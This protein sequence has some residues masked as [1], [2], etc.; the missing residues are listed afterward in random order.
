MR[1]IVRVKVPCSTSNL[2][3]GLDCLGLALS[4]YFDLTVS[5]DSKHKTSFEWQG[6]P[7]AP[8]SVEAARALIMRSLETVFNAVGREM[9]PLQI[10]VR[11]EIPI[12]AGLGSSGAA[13]VGGL[14]AA[15]RLCD[16]ALGQEDIITLATEIEGHPDNVSPAVCGGLTISYMVGK[17]VVVHPC[18]IA[19]PL[20][21]AIVLPAVEK[22]ST[23]QT[24]KLFPR[25][26]DL[27]D[28]LHNQSRTAAIVA[29]LLQGD[30]K[31]GRVL[32]DD[33]LHQRQRSSLMP[34]LFDATQAA[35]DAGALGAF[36][37]GAG[38]AVAALCRAEELAI[39]LEAMDNA[40]AAHG[41]P[42][43]RFG[44]DVAAGGAEYLPLR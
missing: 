29:G 22:E 3:P 2:G 10:M 37:S 44:L 1:K 18:R 15:N 20:K 16:D 6:E 4:L 26:V 28:A 11:S 33:R 38:P 23:A 35:Y 41:L 39:V 31:Q 14:L 32:F 5:L 13:I 34:W 9:T 17:E 42:S 43:R 21:V 27:A 30:L 36:L 19:K 7:L 12:R 24:R 8:Q 25:K 40:I